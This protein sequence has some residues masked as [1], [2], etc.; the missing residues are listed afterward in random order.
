MSAIES[1]PKIKQEDLLKAVLNQ[2]DQTLAVL[3][4]ELNETYAYW[5]VVKYKQLPESYTHKQLWTA[6]KASRI[7]NRI[8]VWPKYDIRLHITNA[9]QR[10]CHAFDMNFGGSWGADELLPAEVKERYLVSSLMEE[11]IFSS[12][13]EGAVTTRR[14]AKDMLRKAMSPKD[15]SQQMIV[16]NYR[17]IQYVVENQ[18]MPLTPERL[19]HIHQLMTEHTL[20]D[21]QAAG[22]FRT[23]DEVVVADGITH[24][25]VHRPPSHTEIPSFVEE[26][27]QFFNDEKPKVF[28]HPII[29]GIIIHFMLAYMHP[30]VDGNGRTARA[31]FYWFLLKQGYW[32]TEFLSISR[33]IAKSK[34]AYE[35]SFLYTE[36]DDNDIGYFV[37]YNLR[38]LDLSF[39]QLQSYLLKKQKEKRAANAFLQSAGINERQAQLIQLF[40]DN[41]KE[42]ITVKYVQ[43]KFLVSPTTAKNDI[44]GL[45]ERQ[46]LCEFAFNKVKNGYRRSEHF[47]DALQTLQG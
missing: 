21:P 18:K 28:I 39:K 33:V 22:R 34:K 25:I 41:P 30:F 9:M 11:A 17:T 2:S 26:L 29:R 23:N 38:V 43:S 1:P 10:M 31:L 35:K 7:G 12:Q 13:M 16:N 40:I 8:E 3:I 44:I 19:L 5:D 47:E 42:I 27:C 37:A 32:L 24:D 6:L 36:A 20:D 4:E 14:V 15:K 46:L 45:V